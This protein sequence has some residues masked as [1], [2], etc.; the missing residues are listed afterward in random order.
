LAQARAAP[1]A[2]S[3]LQKVRKANERWAAHVGTVMFVLLPLFALCLKVVNFHARL[4]YA[5]HLVFA[6][7]L[8]AFWFIMLAVMRL[9]WE[10]LSWLGSALMAVYTLKAGGRVYPGPWQLRA[11]R[12]LALTLLYLGLLALTVPL[13]FLLA[14]LL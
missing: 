4:P 1:D 13:A 6:L 11:L 14:L 9:S 3:F 8:H 7:H 12:A 5:A 2:R 10:P